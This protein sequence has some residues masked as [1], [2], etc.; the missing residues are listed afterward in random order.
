MQPTQLI[1]K[2]LGFVLKLIIEET[3]SLKIEEA[4]AFESKLLKPKRLKPIRIEEAEAYM[5]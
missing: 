5:N 1:L 4:E 3:T 2:S